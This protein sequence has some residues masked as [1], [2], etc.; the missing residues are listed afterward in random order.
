M[1]AEQWISIALHEIVVDGGFSIYDKFLSYL[2]CVYFLENIYDNQHGLKS[3]MAMPDI[4]VIN[5]I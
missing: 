5:E 1:R 4:L 2:C 3:K